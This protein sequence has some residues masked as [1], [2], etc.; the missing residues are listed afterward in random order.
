MNINIGD[1]VRMRKKHPCGCDVFRITRIGMD[2]KMV[3]EKCGHE[4]LMTRKAAEKGIKKI[5]S[6]GANNV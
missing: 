2:F 6:D 1:R 5:L 3:C 4:V